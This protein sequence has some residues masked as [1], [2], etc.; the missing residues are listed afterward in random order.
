MDQKSTLNATDQAAGLWRTRT[1][2]TTADW[3]P[4]TKLIHAVRES[5]AGYFFN[6]NPFKN[7]LPGDNAPENLK[8]KVQSHGNSRVTVIQG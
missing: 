5:G 3:T 1:T 2:V 7:I 8:C 6:V 4:P